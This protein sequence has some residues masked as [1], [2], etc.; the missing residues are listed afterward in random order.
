[1]EDWYRG[2]LARVPVGSISRELDRRRAESSRD[3][4]GD[5]AQDYVIA[6]SLTGLI[7]MPV[8][9]AD[10]APS[11]ARNDDAGRAGHIEAATLATNKAETGRGTQGIGD[12]PRM[13]A[14]R[15]GGMDGATPPPSL[16][17]VFLSLTSAPTADVAASEPVLHPAHVAAAVNAVSSATGVFPTSDSPAE[18]LA[19]LADWFRWERRVRGGN[20]DPDDCSA[21]SPIGTAPASSNGLRRGRADAREAAKVG[22]PQVA[23]V[24]GNAAAS[25]ASRRP[26]TARSHTNSPLS[27]GAASPNI[28]ARASASPG[29]LR[30]NTP[31]VAS[32]LGAPEYTRRPAT[33]QAAILRPDPLS[34]TLG[35][36]KEPSADALMEALRPYTA[37]LLSTA[38]PPPGVPTLSSRDLI[39]AA[40]QVERFCGKRVPSLPQQKREYLSLIHI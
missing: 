12:A 26:S 29:N 30:P 32:S 11:A 28:P 22:S 34:S 18:Q 8:T 9:R 37:A 36:G 27:S 6:P 1:M 35:N 40:H 33:A 10:P 2:F 25:A 4:G 15:S 39:L 13:P 24:G 20:A 5:S 31:T 16:N 23:G 7:S 19:F 3:T 38:T 17:A 21:S 14:I